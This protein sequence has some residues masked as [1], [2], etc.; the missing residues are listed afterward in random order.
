MTS[1]KILIVDDEP[2]ILDGLST[3]LLGE[4]YT[5]LTAT[6]GLIA[7][8]IVRQHA[9][10]L[11]L[12]DWSLPQGAG[13]DWLRKWRNDAIDIPVIML[14]SRSHVID[15][16]LGLEMGADDFVTKPFEP[17]ELLARIHARLRSGTKKSAAD[18]TKR[19]SIVQGLIRM[20]LHSHEV[21][22]RDMPVDIS[23]MEWSLLKILM[24]N[25]GKVFS[26]D[27]LLNQVWGFE[28]YP[29][30]RTVDTH[31]LQLRQKFIPDYFETVRGV[32]YRFRIPEQ[33]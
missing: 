16:V 10:N 23:R 13:I 30:T 15:K 11:V 29:T 4:G 1:P 17:R 18:S 31:I 25:P 33:S 20:E 22:L 12:L 7:D 2:T 5:I 26:R 6:S 14:T 8:Q 24:E 28:N 21:F 3:F 27:E 32:G 9:P 19:Q